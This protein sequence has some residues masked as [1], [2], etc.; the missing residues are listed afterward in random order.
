MR[1]S[2][3][4]TELLTDLVNELPEG[5]LEAVVQDLQEVG[6]EGFKESL[7]E[8]TNVRKKSLAGDVSQ[9]PGC[10]RQG[11]Q[12]RGP[13]LKEPWLEEQRRLRHKATWQKSLT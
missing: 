8:L 6:I 7:P 4:V 5:S 12:L 10:E 3:L 1:R 11:V 9:L 13:G 2:V